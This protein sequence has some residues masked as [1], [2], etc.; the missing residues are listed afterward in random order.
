LL[1]SPVELPPTTESTDADGITTIV[2]WKLNEH[3]KKVKVTRRV[4]RKLQTQLVSH[5]VAERKH[6]AK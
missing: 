2:S 6:W 4:R 5:T 3:D 1:T